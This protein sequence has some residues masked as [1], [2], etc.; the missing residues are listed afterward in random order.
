[1]RNYFHAWTDGSDHIIFFNNVR[2]KNTVNSWRIETILMNIITDQSRNMSSPGNSRTIFKVIIRKIKLFLLEQL[3][4]S[5]NHLNAKITAT[6]SGTGTW[7]PDAQQ[8][9]FLVNKPSFD[10]MMS[11]NPA[12]LHLPWMHLIQSYLENILKK[13]EL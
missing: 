10:F 4:S 7:S 13:S 9:I 8:T 12:L 6:N 5:C 11:N 3:F 1:M 2:L